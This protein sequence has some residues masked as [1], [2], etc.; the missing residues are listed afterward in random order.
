M[1]LSFR[2]S[3]R[4]FLCPGIDECTREYNN[5]LVTTTVFAGFFSVAST[6][7]SAQAIA[8]YL[9]VLY[10]LVLVELVA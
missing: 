8:S 7:L 3:L 6:G 4:V 5:N 1:S 2:V 9:K 10:N